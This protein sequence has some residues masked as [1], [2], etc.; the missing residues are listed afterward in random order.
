MS[1][2]VKSSC[3]QPAGAALWGR[4]PKRRQRVVAYPE[5]KPQ[6]LMLVERQL[7]GLTACFKC[8]LQLILVYSQTSADFF[9]NSLLVDQ[10][11]YCHILKTS[12]VQVCTMLHGLTVSLKQT[13]LNQLEEQAEV[14]QNFTGVLSCEKLENKLRLVKK[15][16]QH[17]A[18]SQMSLQ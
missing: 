13:L 3:F 4:G 15:S 18:L 6:T 17:S 14:E 1:S 16:L 2:K 8:E 11:L 12:F 7:R 9:T 10:L 5:K